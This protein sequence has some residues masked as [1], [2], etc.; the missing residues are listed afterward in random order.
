M[1]YVPDSTIDSSRRMLRSKLGPSSVNCYSSPTLT[2]ARLRVPRR[3]HASSSPQI[4][5]CPSSCHWMTRSTSA[6]TCFRE[7]SAL[8]LVLAPA[9]TDF[10]HQTQHP[11]PGCT[12]P[13]PFAAPHPRAG[14]LGAPPSVPCLR[15]RGSS[16]ALIRLLA[17]P[18]LSSSSS[19]PLLVRGRLTCNQVHRDSRNVRPT[20]ASFRTSNGLLRSS[21]YVVICSALGDSPV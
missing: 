6:P 12:A 1:K 3:R 19:L 13:A 5:L 10:T 17:L 21:P 7:L 20:L 8:L 2:R 11:S 18:R 14:R 16:Q 15:I 9:I 4:L